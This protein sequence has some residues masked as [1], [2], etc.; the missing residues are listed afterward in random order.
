MW[1]RSRT[2]ARMS[3]GSRAR[4][5]PQGKENQLVRGIGI[6]G[7]TANIVNA[8]VGAGIFALPAAV[9]AQMG[10]ASP[11]SYLICAVAMCLFVTSFAMAGSRVSLTGG[12]YAYVEVAFG[13][14]LGFIAGVL[15]FLTAILAVSGIVDLIAI[16]I[17]H[18]VAPLASGAGRSDRKSTRLNS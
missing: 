2:I 9:A 14:Y 3:E 4:V 5:E 18:L 17:G 13:R 16:S 7:L 11:I 15:Y 10:S 8:T 12:L 1:N 6:P